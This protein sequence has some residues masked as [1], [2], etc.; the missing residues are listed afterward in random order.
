[1]VAY[2]LNGCRGMTYTAIG[3]KHVGIGHLCIA[4][5]SCSGQASKRISTSA[6]GQICGHSSRRLRATWRATCPG[7]GRILPLIAG[8]TFNQMYCIPLLDLVRG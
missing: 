2:L 4:S 6:S 8:C 7:I 1:M 5:V 3:A